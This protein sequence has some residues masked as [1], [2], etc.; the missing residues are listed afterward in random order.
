MKRLWKTKIANLSACTTTELSNLLSSCFTAIKIH[1]I[2]YCEKSMISQKNICL[3]QLK[4]STEVLDQLK[5]KGFRASSLF[6]Y[7]F[8]TLYTALPHNLIKTK[9]IK[10]IETTFHREGTLYLA[11]DDKTAF[12]TS[13]DQKR[14]LIWSCQKVC[15]ALI[16]LL[17]RIL[18]DL[19]LN[20][21]DKL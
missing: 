2:R 8:S 5:Y 11:D 10:L 14:F 15:D 1:V 13:D 16:Y 20:Y 9:L 6:A 17:D 7:D 19:I 21:T 12:F 4:K 18:L 3:G